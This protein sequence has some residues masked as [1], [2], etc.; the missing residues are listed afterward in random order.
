MAQDW[1]ERDY[2]STQERTTSWTIAESAEV[3]YE[4]PSASH[5]TP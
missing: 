4:D 3:D 5:D 1:A 2:S